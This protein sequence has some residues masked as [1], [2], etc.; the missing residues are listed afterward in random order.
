MKFR[1]IFGAAVLVSAAYVH[2][3]ASPPETATSEEKLGAQ[4]S[5]T[6]EFVASSALLLDS[7]KE[8]LKD[9]IDEARTHQRVGKA[10]VAAWPD[11]E[12]PQNGQKLDGVDRE[13]A[14][15][16][17]RVVRDFLRGQL[18]IPE[19][20]TFNMS[21]PASWFARV[22]DTPEAKVKRILSPKGV[23]PPEVADEYYRLHAKAKKAVILL[24]LQ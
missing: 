24:F 1:R 8:K 16:R 23:P 4:R 9:L 17:A 6:I 14:A 20:K 13:L 22:L 21:H 19:V 3:V 10:Y 18:G 15:Q 2:S 5:L 7:E 12:F 11:K